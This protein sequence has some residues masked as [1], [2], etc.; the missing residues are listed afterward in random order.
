MP[1]N[2]E[3]EQ[4]SQD[5]KNGFPYRV[6]SKR[7]QSI[8]TKE[9]PDRNARVHPNAKEG[10]QHDGYPSGDLLDFHCPDCGLDFTV[11]LAQ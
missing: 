6:Y 8:C 9:K 11:E 1:T 7:D 5:E 3:I 4:M 2:K 10:D